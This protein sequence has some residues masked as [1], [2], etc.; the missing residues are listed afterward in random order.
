M[1]LIRL[2]RRRLTAWEEDADTLVDVEF[3]NRDGTI[4]LRPSVYEV[5]VAEADGPSFALRARSEHHAAMELGLG[6]PC[7]EHDLSAWHDVDHQSPGNPRFE[8]IRDSHRELVFESPEQLR[9]FLHE[10]LPEARRTAVL[11]KKGDIRGYASERMRRA[12]AEW[13]RAHSEGWIAKWKLP[14]PPT[15]D[16]G[17]GEP[18]GSAGVG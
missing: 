10:V 1:A 8:F 11:H 14:L 16:C 18:G 12:D 17:D 2:M 7:R 9:Q 3:R 15:E 4:D 6:S 13:L 5:D